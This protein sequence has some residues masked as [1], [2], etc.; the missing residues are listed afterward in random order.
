MGG[1]DTNKPVE[2]K[3]LVFA[4][5]RENYTDLYEDGDHCDAMRALSCLSV[6]GIQILVIMDQLDL[7]ETH[8]DTERYKQ[9]QEHVCYCHLME[10]GCQ[11]C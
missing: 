5:L 8:S 11:Y 6:V 2:R 1:K 10:I 9:L 3:P 4:M 7:T